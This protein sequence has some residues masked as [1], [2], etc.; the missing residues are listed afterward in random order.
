[1]YTMWFFFFF[2]LIKDS[3]H[4]GTFGKYKNHKEE[5][6]KKTVIPLFTITILVYKNRLFIY[7]YVFYF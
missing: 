4:C 1:M 6:I 5:N 7:D 3:D 2:L